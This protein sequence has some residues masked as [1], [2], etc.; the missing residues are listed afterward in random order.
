MLKSILL[1]RESIDKYFEIYPLKKGKDRYLYKA[2][3]SL[4]L[5][6]ENLKIIDTLKQITK[7]LE[8]ENSSLIEALIAIDYCL[9]LFEGAKAVNR[10]NPK[11]I[12]TLNSG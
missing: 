10:D 9:A 1:N 7:A 3:V 8:Y 4:T 11:L 6:S 5:N 2:T 12:E